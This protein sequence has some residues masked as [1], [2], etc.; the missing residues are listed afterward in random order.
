MKDGSVVSLTP[1]ATESSHRGH[2]PPKLV[3]ET[4]MCPEGQE[5]IGFHGNFGL[6]MHAIGIITA[7]TREIKTPEKY[8][9]KMDVD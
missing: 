8:G 6:Y 4:V 2:C 1:P 3:Y 9:D 5:L 7:P